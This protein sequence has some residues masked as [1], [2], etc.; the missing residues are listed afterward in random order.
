MAA[1]DV[2]GGGAAGMGPPQIGGGATAAA[3]GAG[4]EGA[5]RGQEMGGWVSPPRPGATQLSGAE[6]DDL[7]DALEDGV[8]AQSCLEAVAE[9]SALVEAHGDAVIRALCDAGGLEAL[10]GALERWDPPL[11]PPPPPLS[12]PSPHQRPPVP[13]ED[14]ASL[15]QQALHFGPLI[16]PP[17]S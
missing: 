9:L 17:G 6:I 14:V 10:A 13:R 3:A 5:G 7:L 2:S 12:S 4:G 16:P 11:H 15:G 8:S 1:G